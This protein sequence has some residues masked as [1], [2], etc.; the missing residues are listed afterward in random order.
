VVNFEEMFGVTAA[1]QVIA[2]PTNLQNRLSTVV[3]EVWIVAA[4]LGGPE[5]VKAFFDCLPEGTPAAFL[6]AQ[7]IDAGCFD[8]LVKS[9][10]RHTALPMTEATQGDQLENGKILVIPVD[11]E[12]TF[13]PQHR[14]HIKNNGWSGPYGPSIDHLVQN[15][16]ERY[17]KKTNLILFSG[18]GSDGTIGATLL[19]Q[20]GGQ[21]WSQTT[22]S[23]IQPSMPDSAH[24]A[25]CVTYRDTPEGLAKHLLQHLSSSAQFS[26]AATAMG[27]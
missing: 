19:K 1:R 14:V 9:I 26:V 20:V 8:S 3:D 24:D 5:P 16:V 18:M 2:L 17:G 27:S 7:H 4:S 10:G 6:Y 13:N 21:V 23:A 15:A 22:D 25:G 12:L 11:H